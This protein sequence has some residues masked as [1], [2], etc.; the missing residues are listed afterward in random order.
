[1]SS[2]TGGHIKDWWLSPHTFGTCLLAMAIDAW[3]SDIFGFE[4]ETFRLE[5]RAQCGK[6]IPQVNMDK[7]LGLIASLSTNT[8]Y[9]SLETFVPVCEA[10]SH[11][12]ADFYKAEPLDPEEAAWGVTE[13]TLNDGQPHAK[14]AQQFSHDVKRY[15][16]VILKQYGIEKPPPVLSFAEMDKPREPVDS[17]FSDDPA[18]VQ[19]HYRR[20]TDETQEITD[21]VR[22]RTHALL[23][24]LGRVPLRNR[25]QEIWRQ[26]SAKALSRLE[27]QKPSVQA[28]RS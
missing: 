25:D 3:G 8:F 10:L 2:L 5:L 21:F 28:T 1:M 24:Q 14:L 15:M 19:A 26:F 23:A 16:G 20:Q 7:L 12:E 13:V 18:M 11:T 17:I 22:T 4:P 27:P 6:D 9:L